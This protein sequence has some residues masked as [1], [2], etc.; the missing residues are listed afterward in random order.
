MRS[1]HEFNHVDEA[2]PQIESFLVN[3][4]SEQKDTAK[5]HD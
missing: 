3:V 2:E 4:S 5:F 1:S